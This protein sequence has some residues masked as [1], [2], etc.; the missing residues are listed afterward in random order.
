MTAVV[1]F[2]Q[3]AESPA[4]VPAPRMLEFAMAFV[5]AVCEGWPYRDAEIARQ[6]GVDRAVVCRWRRKKAGFTDWLRRPCMAHRNGGMELPLNRALQLGIRG[7]LEH[8]EFYANTPARWSRR[9]C[10][11]PAVGAVRRRWRS[12]AT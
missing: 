1:N 6:V 12:P 3:P 11:R 8:M 4:F 9:S 7:S 5:S 10:G 2:G